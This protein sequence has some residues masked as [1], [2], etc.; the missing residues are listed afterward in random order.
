MGSANSEN[1]L[2]T[3]AVTTSAAI[4]HTAYEI[5]VTPVVTDTT[6]GPLTLTN[7]GARTPAGDCWR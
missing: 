4:G 1:D 5:R 3:G 6:C 2:Y 7:T